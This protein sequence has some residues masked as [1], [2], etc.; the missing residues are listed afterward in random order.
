M[1]NDTD[2]DPSKREATLVKHIKE[3]KVVP[4]AEL[5][6]D[7]GHAT[8][9]LSPLT[10]GTP[11]TLGEYFGPGNYMETLDNLRKTG[12]PMDAALALIGT[13]TYLLARYAWP[14]VVELE[15]TRGLEEASGK[16]WREAA[17]SLFE[18]AEHLVEKFVD[19][20]DEGEEE[21]EDSD[22]EGEASEEEAS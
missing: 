12:K 3:M 15:L 14:E 17:A 7:L 18:H 19:E 4:A 11:A 22:E 1:Y 20:D 8:Y 21:E 10:D 2:V 16:P 5:T 9:A 13:H 6:K